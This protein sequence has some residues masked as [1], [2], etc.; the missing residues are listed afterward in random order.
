MG[1]D[2]DFPY[3]V[4]IMDWDI[5]MPD[6]EPLIGCAA[7]CADTSYPASAD[8]EAQRKPTTDPL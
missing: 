5:T 7:S 2:K 3:L 6:T 1:F 4:G 8:E